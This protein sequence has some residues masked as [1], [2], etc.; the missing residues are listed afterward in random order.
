MLSIAYFSI[1]NLSTPKPKA[2]PRYLE[3]SIP[4]AFRT[5]VCTIPAPST[6]NQPVPLQ[7]LQPLPP[8]ITQ[9]ISTSILG[10]V[11]GK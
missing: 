7:T 10:S 8:Q 5:F 11:K 9:P 4:Q 1:A 6:S 2:K 3:T